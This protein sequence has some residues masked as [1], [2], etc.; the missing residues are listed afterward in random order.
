MRSH[1][2][3]PKQAPE[4]HFFVDPVNEAR[5][6]LAVAEKFTAFTKSAATGKTL[7]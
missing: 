2:P 1:P 5:V 7:K 6:L 3:P 4:V